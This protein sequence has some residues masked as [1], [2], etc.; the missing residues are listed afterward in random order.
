MLDQATQSAYDARRDLAG[1]P[2]RAGCYAPWSSLYFNTN[3][4]VVA[5]CKN[6]RYVFGNVARERLD[7]IW[8]G[9]RVKAL[10]AAMQ[11]YAFGLGCEFCEWQIRGKQW[12]G[13]HAARYEDLPLPP[14]ADEVGWPSSMEFAMS[15]TCNLA[16]IMCYGVLSSTIRAHREK[17]PPLPRVYDDVFFAD[18]AKYL[19]HLREARFVGGEPFLMPESYRVWDLMIE[20]GLSTPCHVTTN[21]TQW[22]AKVERVLEALPISISVS[23][24]GV[25]KATVESIRQNAD[26]DTVRQNVLRFADYV[27][28]R[29]TSISMSFCLMQQNW[30]EFGAY[31]EF[32]EGLGAP[33]YVHTVIHPDRSSLFTLPA[34][35][36]QAVIDE[37]ERE[38]DRYVV[39]PRNGH[40]YREA[41]ESL[42]VHLREQGARSV[43]A[44]KRSASDLRLNEG[45][46]PLERAA[47]MIEKGRHDDALALVEP[48]LATPMDK[49]ADKS[50]HY[51]ALTLR[52]RALRLTG[53]DGAEAALDAAIALWPKAPNAFVERAWL[54]LNAERVPEALADARAAVAAIGD[55]RAHVLAPDAFDVFGLASAAAGDA[56]TA[57]T[58]MDELV[59]LRPN[60]ADTF[61]HR[62][63]VLVRAGRVD[64]A[65]S[66]LDEA[67]DLAPDSAEALQLRASLS[68]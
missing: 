20:Q 6:T 11:K 47:A 57:V 53:R 66:S 25:S 3:G 48:V 14:A 19:P 35:R 15:N 36:L 7:D 55:D 42:R 37:L 29:G 64:E 13:L 43:D 16:C 28:R 26:F 67:L 52:G 24:D 50:A 41:L 38:Q 65:R 17:L 1:K 59:Q 45:N 60:A 49:V 32:A 51:L 54:R 21:G 58:A 31:L 10:R 2:F 61:V 44:V 62:A 40:V 39:L 68:G 18:L 63:W 23:M 22:G 27:R 34:K 46:D 30:R 33:V 5:C 12:S 56:A 4:D 9:P 8:R